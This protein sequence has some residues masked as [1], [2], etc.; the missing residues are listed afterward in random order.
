MVLR[1]MN[2]FVKGNTM[3]ETVHVSNTILL[4]ELG[5][6][7]CKVVA[8]IRTIPDAFRKDNSLQVI[9]QTV[10]RLFK[11]CFDQL[12]TLVINHGPPSLRIDYE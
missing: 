10:I 7:N 9:S 11:Q 1:F 5:S 12:T 3:D 6:F 4:G 2:V 8:Y